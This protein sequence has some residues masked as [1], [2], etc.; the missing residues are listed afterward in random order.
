MTS[1]EMET[2]CPGALIRDDLYFFLVLE[3]LRHLEHSYVAFP[4]CELQPVSRASVSGPPWIFSRAVWDIL[5]NWD[6]AK[7]IA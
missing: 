6:D 4:I 7:R 3:P 5:P 2:L 1:T